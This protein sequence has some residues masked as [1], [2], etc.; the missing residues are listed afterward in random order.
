MLICDIL[1]CYGSIIYKICVKIQLHLDSRVCV[2]KRHVNSVFYIWTCFEWYKFFLIINHLNYSCVNDKTIL[3]TK[4]CLWGDTITAQ[5]HITKQEGLGCLSQISVSL[6][7]ECYNCH[8]LRCD[9]VGNKHFQVTNIILFWIL[10]LSWPVQR[11]SASH[12]LSCMQ[13]MQLQIQNHSLWK[14]V[15]ITGKQANSLMHST[16]SENHLVSI[17]HCRKLN[18]RCYK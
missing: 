6:N 8:P 9:V 11:L 17:R 4:K 14:H 12:G 3:Y 13:L 5:V 7:S 15:H 16:K 10:V 1:L 18:D 2:F